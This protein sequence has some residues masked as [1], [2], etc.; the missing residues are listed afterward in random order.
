MKVKPI[1]LVFKGY[2]V[3]EDGVWVAVCLDFCLAAQADTVEEAMEK[4]MLQIAE[5][6]YDAVAGEDRDQGDYL[7]H[8]RKAPL[9]YWVTYYRL[10]LLHAIRL[11]G[12]EAARLL[13]GPL[14]LRLARPTA[15]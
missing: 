11:L 5:Y 15:A 3:R 7:L 6:V 12:N 2:A 13:D 8:R 9:A 1:D 4:L 10:R 14:P